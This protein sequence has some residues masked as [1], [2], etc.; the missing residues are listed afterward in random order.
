MK[1]FG[2]SKS[3]S[4]VKGLIGYFNLSDWWFSEFTENE[5]THILNTYQPFGGGGKSLIKGEVISSNQSS[6]HF[7][8]ILAGYFDNN[9]DRPIADKILRKAEELTDN[10]T[11]VLDRHFHLN[12]LIEIYYK[13]RLDDPQAFKHAMEACKKQIEI[14]PQA[15]NVFKKQST[16]GFIPSHRGFTQLTTIEEKRGNYQ[17]VIELARTAKS[18]GWRG[19]WD[20]RILRCQKKL[21]S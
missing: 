12:S 5:R 4:K 18:Q 16:D 21:S 1:L 3:N 17:E 6:L 2:S 11:N 8:T 15:I 9:N 20:K 13:Q 14:A 10:K 7:L 19:D